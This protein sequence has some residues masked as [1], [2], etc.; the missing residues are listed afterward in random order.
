MLTT[1][2]GIP[3][4]LPFQNPK[5]KSGWRRPEEPIDATIALEFAATGSE[6]T[7]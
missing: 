4:E 2:I 3:I 1:V 7:R 5:P 6:S